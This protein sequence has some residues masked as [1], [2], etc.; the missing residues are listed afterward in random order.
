MFAHQYNPEDTIVAIATPAGKGAVGIIRISGRHTFQ[1]VENILKKSMQN[2]PSHTIH[3]NK[4]YD[5]D[6]LID[7]GLVLK[8]EGPNSYTG[9]DTIELNS[10]GSPLILQKILQ[11]LINKGARL[12]AAGEFTFRAFMNGKL[13]LTQ[14][15]AVADVINAESEK[16]LSNALK[17]LKGGFSKS[18]QQ[19]RTDLIKFAS[20]IELELDFG[21]E[22]VEFAERNDL[23][24]KIDELRLEITQLTDSFKIGNAISKGIPTAIV[25]KPNAGKS[26]LLNTLLNDDRAIVSNIA[27]TTRDTIEELFNIKGLLFRLIDTAG[28]RETEDVIEK[29]GV[30]K[31]LEKI[32]EAELILYLIDALTF[33]IKEI[34][35]L[36][37]ASYHQRSKLLI[38]FNKI[39]LIGADE[40]LKIQ[41]II[42]SENIAQ[43]NIST[44]YLSTKTQVG[45]SELKELMSEDIILHLRENEQ[46]LTNSRHYEALTKAN[47]QLFLCK[48]AIEQKISNDLLAEELKLA[49][50]YLGEISG[51]ISNDD[52]LESIF[53][54]FCI[55]K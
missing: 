3:L 20:L 41:N 7:E 5:N 14:A 2:W 36:I 29:I 28:I 46:I 54:D 39:D 4:F 16:G 13:D 9:E 33:D 40:L 43:G 22:D 15:E 19:L 53:R 32:Q 47:D 27:G 8:F 50:Y 34:K 31:A 38:V 51:S 30:Q 23:L 18:I 24:D 25:G 21:E 1:I 10:H 48:E 12:A 6:T 42:A 11:S 45:I 52:L 26:S 37:D 55:G 49:L 17:H 35:A 44:H